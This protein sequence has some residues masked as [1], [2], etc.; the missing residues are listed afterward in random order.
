MCKNKVFL[1]L[2]Q[3][4]SMLKKTF[5]TL[6]DLKN[7]Y[8]KTLH[9]IYP[10]PEIVELFY[11][12]IYNRL[13]LS[14]V[15]V[16]LHYQKTFEVT[17]LLEDLL[18]LGKGEPIQYIYNNTTFYNLPFF[19]TPDVL[20]PRQETEELVQMILNAIMNI[21]NPVI[22]DIGT[23]SGAIAIALSHE[24]ADVQVY[25]T[26]FSTKAIEVAKFNAKQN[27]VNITFVH[28]DI[29]HDPIISLPDH[30]HV[31]VSN[32][33]YIPQSKI[34]ELHQNVVDYEPHNAL[35]VPDD[36]PI[37]FYKRIADVACQK[38]KNHGLLFFE[39]FET[40][41]AEIMD[42]L[43]NN[44]FSNIQSIKDINEKERFII[45]KKIVHLR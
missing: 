13:K 35:F 20:I 16:L 9:S 28:H 37:V 5:L 41:H 29:L 39:T 15:D 8:V 19:V 10:I 40:Y 18:R 31:V 24:R 34:S 44:R 6:M 11:I 27:G 33:P 38:L 25:A 7:L 21:K 43:K 23:G 45:A 22:M 30:C 36:D 12:S 26:D 1:P 17:I 2:N 42:H 32:P 3:M 4:K 14:K